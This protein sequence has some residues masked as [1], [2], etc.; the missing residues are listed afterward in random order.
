MR[1]WLLVTLAL[2][3]G[4]ARGDATGVVTL[5]D[6]N[7][8]L[9][10]ATTWYK[11][12]PGARVEESDIV[13]T[14]ERGGVQVEFA[15]GSIVNL[16]GGTLYIVPAG[17]KVKSGATTLFM[18]RGWAK[19][20]ARAPGVNLRAASAEVAIAGGALVTQ[21]DGARFD[22]FVEAGSARFTTLAP[23]GSAQ[24]T[25]DAKQD[26]YWSKSASGAFVPSARPPKTFVD[27]MPRHFAD[28]LPSFARKFVTRPQLA[29][30][31]EVSY[32]EA[33]PW[34]AGSDRAVFERRFASRLAD[35]VFRKAVEP[36]VARY[37][38]WDRRLHPEKYA[39]PVVPNR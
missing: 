34:L 18:P 36:D 14:R 37:P 13:D 7:P 28:P 32:A 23:S 17:P 24:G 29:A 25:Q 6:G 15:G 4:S 21:T 8:R 9:L 38:S 35:P 27:A 30:D 12:V 5:V 19:V 39:P 31:G 3:A 11:V 16:V 22:T 2:I 1:P 10:R 26:E 33:Q 20:V